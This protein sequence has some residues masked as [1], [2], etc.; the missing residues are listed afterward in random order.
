MTQ[1]SEGPTEA[2]ARRKS[3]DL[4]KRET[5]EALLV[6]GIAAFSEEGIDAPSLDSICARAGYTRGAFYVH[7]KDRDEFLGEVMTTV[8]QNLID[9]LVATGNA[10]QDLEMTI[11]SFVSAVQA[12][13][14]PISGGVQMH[15]F[16]AACARSPAIRARYVEVLQESVRRVSDV[17]REGQGVGT[18]RAD[19]DATQIGTLIIGLVVAVT[20]MLEVEYPMDIGVTAAVLQSL[21]KPT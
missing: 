14:F 4:A 13:T 11:A 21:L 17:V 19:V 2:A 1:D 10:A 6:A 12:G 9:A 5:R 15:Q 16:A 18:V 3:R 7:F 8:F 20:S